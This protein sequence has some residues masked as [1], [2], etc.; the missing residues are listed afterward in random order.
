MLV[1]KAEFPS[2][3]S[4]ILFLWLHE[5]K[6]SVLRDERFPSPYSGIFLSAAGQPLEDLNQEFPSPYSGI[7]FLFRNIGIEEGGRILTFPS[8]HSGILFLSS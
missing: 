4:G 3:H 7:L 5:V 1:T 2:P 8:P 6:A